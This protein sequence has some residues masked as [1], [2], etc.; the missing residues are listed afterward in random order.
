M[1][2]TGKKNHSV[3]LSLVSGSYYSLMQPCLLPPS[4]RMLWYGGALLLLGWT[5]A[6]FSE[7]PSL[8]LD[9]KWES[10]KTT[11]QK[12]YNALDEER[13]R[14]AIWEKNVQLIEAHNQAY[15]LGLHSYE[16][17]MNSLGDMTSE[18]VA[19]KM[20]GLRA[21]RIKMS[22]NTFLPD[23]DLEKLPKSIDY[24]KKG[25]VTPV[26][27]QGSCGSCWAFSSVGALEGQLMKTTGKLVPLS[28]QN[29]V[30]CVTENDGCG[31][32]YMTNSFKYVQNNDGIDSEEAYHYVGEDQSCAYNVSG[33][34]ATC[35]GYKEIPE[36]DEKAL[37]AAVAQVG[38]VSVGID[39]S[40]TSF[41]FY[42][43]GEVKS[44]RFLVR[45]AETLKPGMPSGCG[46]EP[47]TPCPPALHATACPPWCCFGSL[48][49]LHWC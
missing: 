11:Y 30:D 12:E 45:L 26:R 47:V 40:L 35:R 28:P 44:S 17:G 41:Q 32:G 27:N 38:P 5:L 19:M 33:K 20:T 24:R 1:A 37:Q 36:G 48:S 31:G 2:T 21:P 23:G 29:L 25:Y 9:A 8:S 4:P 15:K 14:R 42:R 3:H 7:D 16:L 18:E 13:F 22:N 46:S 39:A 43:K 10:W 49:M 6:S 34:A